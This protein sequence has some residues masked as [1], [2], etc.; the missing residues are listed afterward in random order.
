M[1]GD[2]F[3]FPSSL[4]REC[5]KLNNWITALYKIGRKQNILK[6]FGRRRNNRGMLWA[7]I[8][9]LGLS[10]AAYGFRR[11]R[12]RNMPNSVQN[13]M[14][15]TRFGNIIPMPKMANLMEFSKE[16]IPNKNFFTKK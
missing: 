3:F 7:S 10:A 14:N 12:N 13:V 11:N 9:G 8:L 16:L 4:S 15:N 5:L 6:M 1:E 2:K